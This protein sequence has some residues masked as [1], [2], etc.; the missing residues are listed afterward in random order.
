[1][2]VIQ[3][4]KRKMSFSGNYLGRHRIIQTTKNYMAE[5]FLWPQWHSAKKTPPKS[6][7]CTLYCTLFFF[8]TL[9]LNAH[10]YTVEKSV[11]AEKNISTRPRMKEKL[12]SNSSSSSC[13]QFFHSCFALVEK[14]WLQL[15]SNS[16]EKSFLH[17]WACRNY[18]SPMKTPKT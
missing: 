6:V 17:P 8:C 11:C 18:Y 1:M 9:F 7:F 15:D 2:E 13:E 14:I 10:F 4:S 5:A 16:F 3:H 12:F